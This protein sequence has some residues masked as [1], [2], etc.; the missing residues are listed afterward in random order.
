M[1]SGTDVRARGHACV[2]ERCEKTRRSFATRQLGGG[3]RW[4]VEEGGGCLVAEAAVAQ[5]LVGVR[6][7]IDSRDAPMVAHD[8]EDDRCVCVAAKDE[9]DAADVTDD[10]ARVRHEVPPREAARALHL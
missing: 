4:V 6:A 8:G 2:H 5:V 1:F 7:R 3:G 9:R 10:R